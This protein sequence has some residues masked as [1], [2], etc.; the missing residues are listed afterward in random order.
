MKKNFAA[1]IIVLFGV[2]TSLPAAVRLPM[3]DLIV[4]TGSAPM[5]GSSEARLTL[6][7]FSDFECPFCARYVRETLP[8]IERDY[9]VT[10]KVKYV[11]RD[12][13][14]DA[15]H[16]QAFKAHEA[17]ACAADQHQFWPMHDRLFANQQTL[18]R[19]ALVAHAAALHI[20]ALAFQECLDSGKH[21]AAIRTSMAEGRAAGVT[22]TPTLMLGLN[23]PGKTTVKV[24]K[25]VRGAQPYAQI[26]D[27]IESLL[28]ESSPTREGLL[29]Q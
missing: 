9:V 15:L 24:L 13:P 14:V 17:A 2:G 7:D 21:A 3:R 25:V 19:A 23:E 22:A 11:F 4:E 27:A 28:R 16:K 18:D 29:H 5:R 8:W 26:K 1:L 12:F 20:D 10:G 6:V